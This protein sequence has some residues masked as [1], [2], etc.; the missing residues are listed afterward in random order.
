MFLANANIKEKASSPTAS[1][2]TPGVF[3]TT[4]LFEIADLMSTRSYPAPYLEIAFN[5]GEEEI[6]LSEI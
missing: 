3:V 5:F 6:T 1:A 4:T 2:F